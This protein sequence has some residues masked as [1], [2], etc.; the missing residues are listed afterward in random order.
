M[1]LTRNRGIARVRHR[2]RLQRFVISGGPGTGKTTLIAALARSGEICYE[3]VSRQVIREQLS[4]GTQL[5]P[6][7]DLSGFAQEC[8]AR[9]RK[10]LMDSTRHARAFFDRGLPDV[11]GYLHHGGLDSPRE[12]ATHSQAYTPVVF[13]APPWREIYVNDSERPQSF[14]ESVAL[15]WHIRRAYAELDFTIVE[16]EL[17]TVQDRLR[18]VRRHLECSTEEKSLWVD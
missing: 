14:E 1:P 16:L 13:V 3:E 11:A 7:N 2:G 5:L 4:Q 6:W 15:S 8:I 17:G 12:L 9:M 18:Q 10:Q